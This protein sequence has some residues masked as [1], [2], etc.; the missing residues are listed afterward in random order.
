[1]GLTQRRAATLRDLSRAVHAGEL[2]LGPTA[3]PADAMAALRRLPGVGEWTAQ[4][5]ALRALGEPDAFP[6]SDLWLRRAAGCASERELLARAE[7]WR[8]WRS[9]A[10]LQLWESLAP[11]DAR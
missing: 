8:P 6:A 4:Y 10:A 7:A 3:D 2:A 11:A 5:V 9:Y 1:M